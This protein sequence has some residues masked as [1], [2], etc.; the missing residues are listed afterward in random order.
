MMSKRA[1]RRSAVGLRGAALLTTWLLLLCGAAVAAEPAPTPLP[2]G[3][4]LKTPRIPA[5]VTGTFRT[6]H[7]K[8]ARD[9]APADNAAV[10]LV[11]VFGGD[12]L[13]PPL[14]RATL[15]MLG[16]E[17]L[18]ETAPLFLPLERYIASL[19]TVPREQVTA[20][21][22][23]LQKSL[24][25]ASEG[26]WK[27]EDFPDVAR[28]LEAN[29]QALGAIA[30]A[31]DKPR[32]Y[33]PMLSSD[34]PRQLVSAS[35][36]IE[37]RLP[38]VA[39]VLAA[40][41]LLSLTNGDVDSAMADLLTGHKLAA[42][43]AAGA[44]FALSLSKANFTDSFALRG[45]TALLE[46]GKLTAEQATAYRQALERIPLAPQAARAADIGERAILRQAIEQLQGDKEE[47]DKLFET[48]LK[49]KK[50][51]GAGEQAV[52]EIKWDLA[53]QRADEI[54]DSIVRTL[55]MSDRALQ[56]SRIVEMDR[57]YKNWQD[58]SEATAR[59]VA[60]SLE[61]KDSTVASRWIGEL[62]AMSVRPLLRQQLL[63][64]NA[65]RARRDLVRLGLA[66]N[67]YERKHGRYPAQ[68]SELVPDFLPELPTGP[69]PAEQ[70]TY[71]RHAAG[72][73]E[74]ISWGPNREYDAGK[75]FND[76][77]SLKFPLPGKVREKSGDQ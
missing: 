1:F 36:A 25:T 57:S 39:R 72:N 10:L 2:E 23:R 28:Y 5:G 52:P 68:L 55:A 45:E 38:F 56:E 48:E 71:V 49:D 63:P 6:L 9:V 34:E 35:L 46:S 58:T 75:S 66:L 22:L 37:R 16:I 67:V 26:P 13:E 24:S 77:H 59:K 50:P 31:A 53:Y 3:L 27:A 40:R 33:M 62:M 64:D 51:A 8:L 65:M 30:A 17:K 41:A 61:E 73:A 21:A 69:A 29:K 20:E 11:Q 12:A 15:D 32:Y 4:V 47:V 42:L 76:D 19:G 7:E 18:S 44:P 74:L 43:L 60:A 70:F 14:R 54:Q